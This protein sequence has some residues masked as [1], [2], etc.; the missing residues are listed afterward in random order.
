MVFKS[1]PLTPTDFLKKIK[2][3]SINLIIEIYNGNKDLKEKIKLLK[4]LENASRV[5][6][7]IDEKGRKFV[8]SDLNYIIDF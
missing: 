4:V 2:L 1:G 5:H 8:A 6:S 3:D 7:V